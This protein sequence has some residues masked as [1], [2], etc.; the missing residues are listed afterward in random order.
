MGVWY[1]TGTV[2]VTNGS[3]NVVGVGT[4]WLT[5]ASIGD[6][7]LGP[8]L[9]EYEIT[10]ITDDTHLAIRQ[11]NGTAAYA[12]TTNSAQVYAIIRN[13][14][15]TMPAQLA[16]QLAAMMTAWHVTTDELTAWLSGTGTVTVHDAVGNAYSVQTPAA[17]NATLTGRLVKSVAGSGDITP[18]SAEAANLFHELTGTRT[19]VGNYIVP[20]GARHYFVYNTTTYAMTVK[21]PAGTGVSVPAG[22]RMLVECDGTN[23]VNA[24]TALDNCTSNTEAA[25]NNSTQLATT[26]YAD[27]L[28]AGTLAGAFTTFSASGTMTSTKSGEVFAQT[29]VSTSAQYGGLGNTGAAITFGVSS[30]LGVLWGAA[31][32]TYYASIGTH[33]NI[34]FIIAANN[35]AIGN[36][37]DTGLA[38]TGVVSPSAHNT[39]D[40]GTT[41]LRWKDLWLQSGAFNGSDARLKTAVVPLTANEINAAK[42][43]SKEIG[44]YQWLESV[45][46][47]GADKARHHVGFTVQRAIEIM[48]ANG[49]DW[50]IYGFIGYDQWA[51]KFVEHAEILPVA[52]VA[53]KEAVLDADE[54]VLAPAVES[55]AA[56]E[57]KA[58][59]TEQTV[60]AGDAYS[61]RY[62][63]LNMFIAAGL[64]ARLAA[65]EVV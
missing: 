22:A 50:T 30:S 63:Q 6:I 46:A 14:T 40:L 54:T 15:S 35:K 52:A 18:T 55:V 65:L 37:S 56:V 60:F 4:L 31:P 42:Q 61:F 53:A 39:S 28:T 16:S 23:V 1:R 62:D 32:A 36:F 12:G 45:A 19:A 48:I 24:F 41:A 3:P 2:A 25:A 20:A 5:Q 17:M 7:F 43:L 64:E 29:V 11:V 13:F 44:T 10:S 27:R 47:K 33:L 49:L 21:T 26:A 59:W 38:V 57:G 9:V 58:A 8:D 51:D 34:P